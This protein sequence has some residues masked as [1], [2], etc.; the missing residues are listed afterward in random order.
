[1]YD[2]KVIKRDMG[3][4]RGDLIKMAMFM[5]SDYTRGVKGVA[6]VNAIEIINS[7]PD[8]KV[9]EEQNEKEL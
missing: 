7:F 3:L 2:V 8:L 1:M 5:G 6:A 9:K 4:D